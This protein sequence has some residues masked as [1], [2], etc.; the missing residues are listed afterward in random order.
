M[1]LGIF[2]GRGKGWQKT[3]DRKWCWNK[4]E[5]EIKVSPASEEDCTDGRVDGRCSKAGRQER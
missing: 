4:S 2:L 1:N 3:E 5:G